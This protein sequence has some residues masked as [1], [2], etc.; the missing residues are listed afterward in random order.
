MSRI[1]I[2]D[3]DQSV[4]SVLCRALKRVGHE[5][6]EAADGRAGLIKI[7]ESSF[8]LVITDIVMPEMEG[9]E[10]ILQLR[11]D[12]PTLKV[13][14]IS[15]GGRMPAKNYLDIARAGGAA[16]VLTKPFEIEEFLAAVETVLKG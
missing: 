2:I 7:S 9:I 5:I 16:K 1:L 11:R 3:D 4:R 12:H 10:L 6:S 14:A 13:I 15:G 8:D